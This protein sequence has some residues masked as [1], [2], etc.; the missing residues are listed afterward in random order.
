NKGGKTGETS[1]GAPSRTAQAKGGVC[2]FAECFPHAAA[3]GNSVE[4][5]TNTAIKMRTLLPSKYFSETKNAPTQANCISAV[6]IVPK[7][8][9]AFQRC[10][11][12]SA[13]KAMSRSA[14]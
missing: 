4:K 9:N 3:A 1:V 14:M 13:S 6:P 7:I 11:S 2:A 12:A 5:A 10:R 8:G